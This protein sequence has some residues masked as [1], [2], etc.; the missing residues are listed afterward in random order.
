[1]YPR[2]HNC[3]GGWTLQYK[4]LQHVQSSIL[5]SEDFQT[6]GMEEIEAVLLA[7]EHVVA[8][9]TSYNSESTPSHK[10]CPSCSY[11]LVPLDAVWCRK[12]GTKLLV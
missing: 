1:M 6:I 7:A 5:P 11:H 9:H 2:Q 3:D 4:F 12:C 8:K 10:V